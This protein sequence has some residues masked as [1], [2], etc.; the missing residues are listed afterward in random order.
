[1]RLTGDVAGEEHAMRVAV[2]DARPDRPCGEP[3]AG[4][5]RPPQRLAR[6]RAGGEDMIGHRLGRAT[7]GA[8]PA[9][10]EP[11]AAD[12][13][14]EAYASRIGVNHAPVAAREDK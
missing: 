3:R 4:E 6:A 2:A 10:V 5:M 9:G 11:I 13:T 8:R 1:M 14:G 12:A 7:A